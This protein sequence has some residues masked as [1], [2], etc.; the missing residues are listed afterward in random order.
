M[1]LTTRQLID[2]LAGMGLAWRE[3]SNG[4]IRC[5][6]GDCPIIAY[7]RHCTGVHPSSKFASQV[8]LSDLGMT[9]ERCSDVMEAADWS[10]SKC[11]SNLRQYMID[12]LKSVAS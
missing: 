3:R 4:W 9:D 12:R 11:D 10:R 6:N 1:T 7:A 8:A 2:E 5:A